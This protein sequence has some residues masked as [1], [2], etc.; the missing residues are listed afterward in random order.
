LIL[1][2]KL[3]LWAWEEELLGKFRSVLVNS[4]LQPDVLDRWVCQY[5]PDGGYFV[6]GVYKILT[7]LGD[8]DA[9]VT[10]DLI[11][12]QQVPLKVSVMAWRLLRNKLPTKDNLVRRHIIPPDASMC[13]TGC[14][15]VETAHHLFLSCPVFAPL[16]SLVRSW[17]GTSS[18]DLLVL[19]DHFLQFT[20]S[21]GDSRARRSFMQ[22]L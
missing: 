21:A 3:V 22:L 17:V 6:R 14:G 7:A 12:H 16:W 4:V 8:Q 2:Q 13:V 10:S 18:T 11:W 1:R 9:T 15:G 5:D 19:H 20:Y